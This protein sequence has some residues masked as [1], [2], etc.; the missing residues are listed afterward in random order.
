MECLNDAIEFR[1]ILKTSDLYLPKEIV[2]YNKGYEGGAE[3]IAD[4]LA[5]RFGTEKAEGCCRGKRS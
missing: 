1:W 2:M 3:D 4:S 5:I